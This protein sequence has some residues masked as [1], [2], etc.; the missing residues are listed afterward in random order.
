MAI[1]YEVNDISQFSDNNEVCLSLIGKYAKYKGH[2]YRITII[3][4]ICF[5]HVFVNDK[6]KIEIPQHE[7]FVYLDKNKNW[8][9]IDEKTNV[10]E[11]TGI[12][13]F[14]FVISDNEKHTRHHDK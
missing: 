14:N 7:P 10:I 3:K 8:V 11:V 13:S 4:D 12:N 6:V 9:T 2:G 5:V 1:P